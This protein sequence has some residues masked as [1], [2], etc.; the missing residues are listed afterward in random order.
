MAKSYEKNSKISK[1]IKT[2]KVNLQ[3]FLCGESVLLFRQYKS[4]LRQDVDGYCK[5]NTYSIR[6]II[7]VVRCQVCV[8]KHDCKLINKVP[9][10]F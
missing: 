8:D 10:I 9:Y 6:F 2:S 1:K 3:L 5:L 7:E 4:K